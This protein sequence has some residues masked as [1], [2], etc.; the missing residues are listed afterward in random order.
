MHTRRIAI[1]ITMT[2]TITMIMVMVM[3]VGRREM[4]SWSRGTCL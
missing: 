2:I 3:V 1:A 4:S